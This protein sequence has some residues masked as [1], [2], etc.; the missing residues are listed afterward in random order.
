MLIIFTVLPRKY[1]MYKLS[2]MVRNRKAAI[3]IAN[4]IY[5]NIIGKLD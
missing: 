2:P 3:Y 5:Y 4:S 1:I